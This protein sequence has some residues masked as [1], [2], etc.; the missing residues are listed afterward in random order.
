MSCLSRW[1]IWV[2]VGISLQILIAQDRN[3][4]SELSS[5]LIGQIHLGLQSSVISAIFPLDFT[6]VV[7]GSVLIDLPIER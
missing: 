6:N 1:L 2:L 5:S 4:L 7:I 3:F